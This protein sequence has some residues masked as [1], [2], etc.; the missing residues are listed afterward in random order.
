MIQVS[1]SWIYSCY[2]FGFFLWS[3]F[4]IPIIPYLLNSLIIRFMRFPLCF[5][6]HFPCVCV[7]LSCFHFLFTCY[8]FLL[9]FHSTFPLPLLCIHVCLPQP[10]LPNGPWIMSVFP[11]FGPLLCLSSQFCSHVR[12]FLPAMCLATCWICVL[13]F[14]VLF[15]QSLVFSV[16][17]FASLCH[18]FYSSQLCMW[19]KHGIV[20]LTYT[21][22]CG[23]SYRQFLP[24]HVQSTKFTIDGLQS[25]RMH[26]SSNM[27]V[28]VKVLNKW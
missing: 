19:E 27:S 7:P 3:Q 24:N 18:Y 8:M 23:T 28:I 1:Q 14:P 9:V 2:C 21:I 12:S 20:S 26:P 25:N 4:T 13:V 17:S 15:R 10:V 16:F 6:P 22:K 5:V 11:S